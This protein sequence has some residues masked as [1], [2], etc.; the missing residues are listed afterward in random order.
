MKCPRCERRLVYTKRLE[1]EVVGT[2]PNTTLFWQ[3]VHR[4]WCPICAVDAVVI[5]PYSFNAAGQ[6][7]QGDI[8]P[9]DI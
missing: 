6:L 7:V 9:E 2:K 5:V 4:W 8:T 3:G 1:H